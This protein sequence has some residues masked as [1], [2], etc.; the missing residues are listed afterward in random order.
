MA[1]GTDRWFNT[2]GRHKP[3]EKPEDWDHRTWPGVLYCLKSREKKWD[4]KQRGIKIV[5]VGGAEFVEKGGGGRERRSEGREVN[6]T[7]H[8]WSPCGWILPFLGIVHSGTFFFL[9]PSSPF[10]PT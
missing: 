8:R 9:L 4:K 1:G 6:P 2:P 3:L 10:Y 5:S 7:G